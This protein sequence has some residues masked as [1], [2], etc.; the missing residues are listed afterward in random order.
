MEAETS[1]TELERVVQLRTTLRE[2]MGPDIVVP[3]S[4][5][6]HPDVLLQLEN[7]I[8]SIICGYRL[9]SNP[10]GRSNG[11]KSF[12]AQFLGSVTF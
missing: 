2:E 9:I 6:E 10:E 12:I 4:L 5:A 7:G 1:P 3:D 8:E 11:V